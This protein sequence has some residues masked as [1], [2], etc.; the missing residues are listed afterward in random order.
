MRAPDNLRAKRA[1]L[2]RMRW[3]RMHGGALSRMILFELGEIARIELEIQKLLFTACCAD[4]RWPRWSTS[5]PGYWPLEVPPAKG[6][7]LP[8]QGTRSPEPGPR[9]A[10]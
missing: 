10:Q 6:K 2:R 1:L 5:C 9:A 8:S 7:F 3:R 4:P